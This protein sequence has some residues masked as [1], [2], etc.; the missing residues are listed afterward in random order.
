M[1]LTHLYEKQEASFP[2]RCSYIRTLVVLEAYGRELFY[3]SNMFN[4]LNS[5]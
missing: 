5:Y 2:L 3:V 1:H 4:M